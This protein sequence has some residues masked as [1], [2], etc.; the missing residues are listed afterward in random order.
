MGAILEHG[1]AA[2]DLRRI[3]PRYGIPVIV[4]PLVWF[5]LWQSSV[6]AFDAEPIEPEAYLQAFVDL[7]LDGL[8]PRLAACRT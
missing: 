4:A 6:G 3:D 1:A 5:F 7:L 2:G 8:R